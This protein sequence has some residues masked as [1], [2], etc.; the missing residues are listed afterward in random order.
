MTIE[1][2]LMSEITYAKNA[3]VGNYDREELN[4]YQSYIDAMMGVLYML[5]KLEHDVTLKEV[6]EFCTKRK[7]EADV[8]EDPCDYC[9]MAEKYSCSDGISFMQCGQIADILPCD[10][11]IV[12]IQK[13]IKEAQ[14]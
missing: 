14:Q 9:P 10:W 4:H 1:E 6:K 11:D 13:H 12:S 7:E 3:M 8:G 2:Y 5:P